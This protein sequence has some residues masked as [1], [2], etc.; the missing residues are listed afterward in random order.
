MS[1]LTRKGSEHVVELLLEILDIFV[2]DTYSLAK[3]NDVC[4]L[5][6]E[7][8]VREPDSELQSIFQLYPDHDRYPTSDLWTKHPVHKSLW[9]IIGR[10][11][12]YVSFTHGRLH[13]SRLEPEIDG[14]PAIKS[15]LIG[16]HGHPAPVLLIELSMTWDLCRLRHIVR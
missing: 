9:N 12:D 3:R 2:N 11:D 13:A 4:M 7:V 15:A 16:G 5:L 1:T 10:S 8:F 6:R 14:H